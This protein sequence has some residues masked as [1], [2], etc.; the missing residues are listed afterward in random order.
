MH[1][2][3]TQFVTYKKIENTHENEKQAVCEMTNIVKILFV[4]GVGK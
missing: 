1:A 3:A 4:M 2:Y